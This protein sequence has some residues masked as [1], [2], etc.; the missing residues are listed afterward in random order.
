MRPPR[1]F[2]AASSTPIPATFLDLYDVNVVG[3]VRLLQLCVPAM[4]ARGGSVIVLSSINADF[5]TP[6]LAAYAATKAALNN[7]VQT[8]ALELAPSTTSDQRD[9]AGQHR[10]SPAARV[11]RAQCR[12][13]A[14][15]C[16]EYRA[17]SARKIGPCRGGRRA[18]VVPRVGPR[19]MD[20]WI[21]LCDRWRRWCHAALRANTFVGVNWGS[22]NFRALL[23]GVDGAVI[24]EYSAP[25]GVVGARPQRH[26]RDNGRTCRALA[27]QR[28][29]L[30]VRHDRIQCWMDRSSVCQ[31]S[32]RLRGPCRCN[33]RDTH[34]QRAGSHR[35][36][37]HVP[38][39]LRW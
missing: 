16:P 35:S 12:P 14:S 9:R 13:R 36:R 6:T 11:V 26:G 27:E 25:A 22:T 5:A 34:R 39:Q 4:R 30:R 8:A 29:D 28:S 10:Y 38:P 18:G 24:D 17:T 31:R 21:D 15:T 32:C 19:T 20:H 3:A 33:R 7:L 37:H 1:A 2:Q 23:I